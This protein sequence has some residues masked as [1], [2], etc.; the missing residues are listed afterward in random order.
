MKQNLTSK[1]PNIVFT[2]PIQF[3]LA[4]FGFGNTPVNS[5]YSIF[6]LLMRTDDSSFSSS[7]WQWKA[8]NIIQV[9]TRQYFLVCTSFWIFLC[10]ISSFFNLETIKLNFFLLFFLMFK[11]FA[12]D[13]VNSFVLGQVKIAMTFLVLLY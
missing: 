7:Y 13:F 4:L 8:I 9:K 11:Y 1:L 6:I 12:A 3:L 10:L 2:L 5:K